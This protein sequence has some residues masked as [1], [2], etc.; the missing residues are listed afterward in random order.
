MTI[1]NQVQLEQPLW[2]FSVGLYQTHVVV[3]DIQPIVLFNVVSAHG[4]F[5]SGLYRSHHSVL[6]KL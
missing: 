2:W 6:I 1:Y 3:G 5:C 4:G